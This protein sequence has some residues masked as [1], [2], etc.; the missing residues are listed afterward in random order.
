MV[1][2]LPKGVDPNTAKVTFAYSASDPSLVT[3]SQ[4]TI[5]HTDEEITVYSPA[6]GHL[7][8]WKNDFSHQRTI[9]DD[10]VAPCM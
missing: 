1:L 5:P 3:T 4:H 2:G 9:A 6:A 7:R 10:Y 8:I